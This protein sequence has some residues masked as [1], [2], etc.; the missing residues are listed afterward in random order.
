M[1]VF[2]IWWRQNWHNLSH[3]KR[4]ASYKCFRCTIIWVILYDK[5][6]HWQCFLTGGRKLL[7][8]IGFSFWKRHIA[9]IRHCSLSLVF[10][11][12]KWD[13]IRWTGL[14]FRRPC[15]G[16]RTRPG[17][18][19]NI[20]PC[21]VHVSGFFTGF[22][23][24]STPISFIQ[25]FNAKWINSIHLSGWTAFRAVQFLHLHRI[26]DNWF[27]WVELGQVSSFLIHVLEHKNH[28]K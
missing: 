28:L 23:T 10:S 11:H 1:F 20:S 19:R 16:I 12:L 14:V 17:R 7:H 8:F 21:W 9:R 13:R 18:C 4:N 27:L 6:Y 5:L 15:W 24:I 22:F 3:L 2:F 26:L 25:F